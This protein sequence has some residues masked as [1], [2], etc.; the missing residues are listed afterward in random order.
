LKYVGI[1]FQYCNTELGEDLGVFDGDDA[2]TGDDLLQ[3]AA[4]GCKLG[5]DKCGAAAPH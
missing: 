3:M 4:S 1:D 2:G 5:C